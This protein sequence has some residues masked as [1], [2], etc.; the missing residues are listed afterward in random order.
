MGAFL[1]V[2]LAPLTG[3]VLDVSHLDPG[4]TGAGKHQIDEIHRY[5]R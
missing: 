3:Y 2:S 4:A 1:L 5:I